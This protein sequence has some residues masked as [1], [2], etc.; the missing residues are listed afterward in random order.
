MY[1]VTLPGFGTCPFGAGQQINPT[2][3]TIGIVDPET[4]LGKT[5]VGTAADGSHRV[6]RIVKNVTGSTL[7]YGYAVKWS[8]TVGRER[9]DVTICTDDTDA[10]AG[11]VCDTY[12]AGV[13]NGYYFRMTVFAEKHKV[14]LGTTSSAR[15]TLTVNQPIVANDDN[16]MIWG[17][18]SAASNNAVQNRIGF[19]L[20]ATTN[21]TSDNGSYIDACISLLRI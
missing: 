18:N 11:V 19:A 6:Y 8:A 14:K 20:Q 9:K 10:P 4:L 12:T 16:G 2:D 15:C 1:A 17:Q 5:Y 3:T 13:R 7:S 21:G